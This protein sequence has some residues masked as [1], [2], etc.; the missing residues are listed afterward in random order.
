MR[1]ITIARTKY[2]IHTR[3][4]FGAISH[5]C[6]CLCASHTIDVVNATDIGSIDYFGS[7]MSI[8]SLRS[9]KH[10]FFTTSNNSWSSQHQHCR[11][12]RCTS[13]RNIQSHTLNG[14][15]LLHTMHTG[16]SFH[17]NHHRLLCFMKSLYV[18]QCMLNGL[19]HF[20]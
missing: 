1:H 14:Y 11:E 3:N 7:N 13:A 10:N 16:L 15:R 5:G 4:A 12:Q 18:M 9:A 8:G 20:G 17:L 2:F 19:L 6:Y